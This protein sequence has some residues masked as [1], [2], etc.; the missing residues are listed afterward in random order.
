MPLPETLP[1]A[2]SSRKKPTTKKVEV[3]KYSTGL[4]TA[5]EASALSPTVEAWKSDVSSTT[6]GNYP[7]TDIYS[8]DNYTTDDDFDEYRDDH[9][10]DSGEECNSSF[11]Y[12]SNSILSTGTGSAS[13]SIGSVAS[14]PSVYSQIYEPRLI[15]KRQEMTTRSARDVEDKT[16]LPDIPEEQHHDDKKIETVSKDKPKPVASWKRLLKRNKSI[17]MGKN[18]NSVVAAGRVSTHSTLRPTNSH[19]HP[20]AT[21]SPVP[22]KQRSSAITN[23]NINSVEESDI[24]PK[25]G[26]ES[27]QN[28]GGTQTDVASS[29]SWLTLSSWLSTQGFEGAQHQS[30]EAKMEKIQGGSITM[31]L[32]TQYD[33]VQ[34]GLE[35]AKRPVAGVMDHEKVHILTDEDDVTTAGKVSSRDLEMSRT[36]RKL[37]AILPMPVSFMRRRKEIRKQQEEQRLRIL[38]ILESEDQN[39]QSQE[40]VMRTK[41]ILKHDKS[42]SQTVE[43]V[44]IAERDDEFLLDY[45]NHTNDMQTGECDRKKETQVPITLKR[46]NASKIECREDPET[47]KIDPVSSD[48]IAVPQEAENEMDMHYLGRAPK[49]HG[50]SS[51]N[52]LKNMVKIAKAERILQHANCS[53]RQKSQASEFVV[54]DPA[55][56]EEKYLGKKKT[57]KSIQEEKRML[58]E[59]DK[60]VKRRLKALEQIE[61]DDNYSSEIK[62][63][64]CGCGLFSG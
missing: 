37:P 18:K 59:M 4:T 31:P 11:S 54:S 38:S 28:A 27:I 39:V 5:E 51:K 7:T 49:Q 55:F 9:L 21:V 12:M 40:S 45:D 6:G 25:E 62:D 14:N 63:D 22:S 48:D 52:H 41:S 61:K 15:Q 3:S 50:S 44:A 29:F 32:Q 46:K 35:S 16:L 30:A 23:K 13:V 47:R 24:A 33:N 43:T 42:A 60:I 2:S 53:A 36:R 64:C 58:K 57:A 8:T 56:Q 10:K 1:R 26:E 17:E 34:D 20:P 19:D